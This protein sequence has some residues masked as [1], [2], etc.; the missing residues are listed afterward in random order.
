MI[1]EK[2]GGE[3][4]ENAASCSYCGAPVAAEHTPV[5]TENPVVDKATEEPGTESP[6]VP[7]ESEASK[8]PERPENVIGGIAGAI[9]GALLG[10]LSIFLLYQIGYVASISGVIIAFCTMKGYALLGGKLTKK[11]IVVSI[12]LILVTPAFGY[13]MTQAIEI[14]KVFPGT[15]LRDAL[16]FVFEL[17]GSEAEFRS[18]VIG[19]LVM[20]YGFT[21]VGAIGTAINT[22][23][24]R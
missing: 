7:E 24:K 18:G 23:K 4:E 11:G 21:A 8:K 16:G 5:E 6:V 19:E 20:L 1:C 17:F 2:C 10:A 14:I 9:V 13:F 15:P 12:L 3:L 22:A